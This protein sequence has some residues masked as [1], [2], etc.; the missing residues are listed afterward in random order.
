[1]VSRTGIYSQNSYFDYSSLSVVTCHTSA[2]VGTKLEIDH[3]GIIVQKT[4]QARQV[5]LEMD[6]SG[7]I[8]QYTPQL[9]QQK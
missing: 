3:N 5:S 6:R 1:M 2:S 7:F 4:P 8:V 9:H